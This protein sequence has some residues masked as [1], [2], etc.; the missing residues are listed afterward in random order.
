MTQRGDSGA[1]IVARSADISADGRYRW[2]LTRRWSAKPPDVWIMLNPSTADA[3]VDDATIKRCIGFSRIHGAGA[4]HVVNLFAYR[5]TD[6]N[7]LK[8]P[9]V[10]DPVGEWN[11]AAIARAVTL[12]R[13]LGGRV[14]AGWGSHATSVHRA[15]HVA[16]LIGGPIYCLGTTRGNHPRHPL[17]LPR[18]APLAVWRH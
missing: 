10:I 7:E 3:E 2:L 9:E 17:Y 16:D 13:S 12:A 5:A 11:D 8:R 1:P 6:P 14:I 4:I 18:T 15:R